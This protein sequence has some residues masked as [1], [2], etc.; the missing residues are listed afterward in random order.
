MIFLSIFK[1]CID[2][3][4]TLA[5]ISHNGSF[6]HVV[7]NHVGFMEEWAVPLYVGKF[8]F[9]TFQ[10]FFRGSSNPFWSKMQML[11]ICTLRLSILA[12]GISS[13]ILSH[14]PKEWWLESLISLIQIFFLLVL[15][16]F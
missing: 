3:V 15:P 2:L 13:R 12:V 5:N 10:R 1:R 9:P 11:V 16:G 6:L 7:Y 4:E 8:S 14:V